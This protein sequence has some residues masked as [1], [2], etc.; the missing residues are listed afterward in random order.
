MIVHG[1]TSF[2]QMLISYQPESTTFQRFTKK[3]LNSKLMIL[4]QTS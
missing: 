1:N 2:E 4:A 3:K